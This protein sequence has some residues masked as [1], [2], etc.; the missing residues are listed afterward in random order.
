MSMITCWAYF[1]LW[2]LLSHYTILG[3]FLQILL[4]F[5]KIIQTRLTSTSIRVLVVIIIFIIYITLLIMTTISWFSTW[6]IVLLLCLVEILLYSVMIYF[7]C[8]LHVI[9]I[10]LL[11]FLIGV[12]ICITNNTWSIWC[13]LLIWFH[14][15]TKI[16]T[17]NL[18]DY[19]HWIYFHFRW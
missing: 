9:I 6:V 16:N 7:T 3:G 10:Q 1:L 14:S 19:S 15:R 17:I 8:L 11:V 5:S 18:I 4:H 2:I 13:F 12:I